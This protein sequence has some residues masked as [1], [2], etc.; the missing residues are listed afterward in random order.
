MAKVNKTKRTTQC[1]KRSI[2]FSILHF[3]LFVGPLLIFVPYAFIVGEV[4]SKVALGLTGITALILLVFSLLVGVKNRAGL[5]RSIVWLLIAGIMFCLKNIQSFIW[6][7]AATTIVDELFI[8][9]LKDKYKTAYN[10]NLEI[11]RRG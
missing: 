11:D 5:H 10:T 4:V 3:L 9:R 2:L 6:I 1:R 7:M 8:T